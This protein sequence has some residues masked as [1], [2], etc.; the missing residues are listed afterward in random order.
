MAMHFPSNSTPLDWKKGMTFVKPYRLSRPGRAFG[1][2]GTT[3]TKSWFPTSS[4]TQ[5]S[6]TWNSARSPR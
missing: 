5:G 2:S 1:S 4:R 3:S 6:L